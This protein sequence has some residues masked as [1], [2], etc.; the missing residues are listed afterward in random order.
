M[1]I[2]C[3]QY[4]TLI[5]DLAYNKTVT[6]TGKDSYLPSILTDEVRDIAVHYL[7]VVRPVEETLAYFTYGTQNSLLY[8]QYL[9]VLEGV[10]MQSKHASDQLHIFFESNLRVNFGLNRW[11]HSVEALVRE[12][13]NPNVDREDDGSEQTSMGHKKLTGRLHYAQDA[14]SLDF[15]SSDRLYD[16]MRTEG[17]FHALAGLG[18]Q[19]PPTAFRLRRGAASK[20]MLQT[21][22][23]HIDRQLDARFQQLELSLMSKLEAMLGYGNVSIDNSTHRMPQ[24]LAQ[25]EEHHGTITAPCNPDKIQV[26]P[27][28]KHHGSPL[29]PQSNSAEQALLLDPVHKPTES[30]AHTPHSEHPTPVSGPQKPPSALPD[31]LSVDPQ[32][33]KVKYK[34]HKVKG[35]TTLVSLPRI[36][37]E[38]LL[39]RNYPSASQLFDSSPSRGTFTTEPPPNNPSPSRSFLSPRVQDNLPSASTAHS[40]PKNNP[41][42]S[43]LFASSSQPNPDFASQASSGNRSETEER[44]GSDKG[45]SSEDREGSEVWDIEMG[46]NPDLNDTG[47]E[48]ETPDR[49]IH[50]D[51]DD[52][53][54]DFIIDEPSSDPLDYIPPFEQT[55]LENIALKAIRKLY[56]CNATFKSDGQ[57]RLLIAVLANRNNVIGILPTGGGKSITW[58]VPSL[59]EEG[60]TAVTVP[61]RPLLQQHLASAEHHKIKAIRWRSKDPRPASDVK[62]VYL[63]WETAKSPSWTS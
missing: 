40:L 50:C 28:P 49:A 24:P 3:F 15:M 32:K 31:Q 41:S 58:M 39:T 52:S 42:A 1:R 37:T 17:V 29:P 62:L 34:P 38:Q 19:N 4:T 47:E 16:L 57:H 21:L 23:H 6:V 53:L 27:T 30:T 9:F 11:R 8:K 13:I 14:G 2:L 20:E 51:S 43:Q 44:D 22:M 61:F 12:F 35:T 36:R 56:G 54:R 46:S 26:A 10:R 45:S 33:S 25:H 59:I 5:N 18:T 7:A 63:A 55:R 60:F 48:R